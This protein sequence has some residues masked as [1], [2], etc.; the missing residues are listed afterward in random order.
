MSWLHTVDAAVFRWIN[1]RMANPLFDAVM[2]S[3]AGNRWFIP[4]AVLGVAGLLW[5]GGLRARLFV[6]I[7]LTTLALGDGLVINTLKDAVGRLRPFHDIPEARLL[8]GRG[9]SGSFPSS[10]TS[11]WCAI[12]LLA[13]IYYPRTRWILVPFAALMGFSRVYLGAHYP[14]DVLAGAVLGAGYAAAGLWTFHWLWQTAGRRW[15]PLWW[16]RLPRFVWPAGERAP[17]PASSPHRTP[18]D[19]RFLENQ[20]WFRLAHLLIFAVLV[21][22]LLFLQSNRIDLSEDE[23]YQWIWSKHLALS[24][25]SK[26]LG[27]A[28]AHWLGTHLWG[29][30]EFGVRFWPPV[31]ATVVALMILRFMRRLADGR[32]ALVTALIFLAT[33]M[34]AVGATLMTIDPLLVL[35]WT[36]AMVV[37]WSAVQTNGTT[38]QWAWAGLWTGLAFLSKYTALA[39]IVCYALYFALWKPARVHLRRPGPWLALGVLLLCTLP[40]VLWN[41]QHGWVT[42]QHVSENAKLEKAWR[43][44][45]RFFIE[46]VGAE[47]GLFNPVFFLGM[48]GAM[49]GLWRTATHQAELRYLFCLGA[50]IFLG[51]WAYTLHSRVQPNWVASGVVPLLCL[52]VLYWRDRWERRRDQLKPWLIAGLALGVLAAVLL[53]DTALI[54][55]I[56]G[57]KLPVAYDPTRRVRGFEKMAALIEQERTQLA[58]PGGAAPFIITSHYGLAG[59]LTFYIPAAQ[60]GLPDHPVVF[61]RYTATP[62]N[63]FYFWP[64]YRYWETRRGHDAL[65]VAYEDGEGQREVPVE[66]ASQFESAEDL[67]VRQVVER[68]LV[69]HTLRLHRLHQVK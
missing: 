57:G 53:C 56:T 36:A 61:P 13:G 8:V 21:G 31:I 7:L 51:Y 15:F 19:R 24:Y 41:S 9:G 6:A 12:T 58:R 35:F 49:W 68:G 52:M 32:T 1:L 34:L 54:G 14:S 59:Q 5:K 26:P 42:V 25:Y 44:T 62:K 38:A 28:V 46:F 20:Q 67:G 18:S 17:A 55:K 23:A 69:L 11:T 39:L 30:T 37:G 66:V 43:P 3:L 10:H 65:Y 64:E 16:E 2:P 29:D 22:R 48:L 47:A 63:Q 60:A 50:P 40:V 33:P 27:I 4:V 45:L